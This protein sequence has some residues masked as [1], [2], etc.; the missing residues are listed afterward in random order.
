MSDENIHISDAEIAAIA[1]RIDRPIVLVGL[2]G[3][4]KSTV[5][6]RLASLVGRDFADADDEIERAAQLSV[7][8]IFARFGE[9]HFR[10]GERRVIARLIEE[11]HGVIA[12]GGG[13]FCDPGTR[14]LILEQAIAVWI[15]C[16]VDT[17]VE[18]T[19]RKNNRPLLANGNPREILT[20]LKAER[21][22]YYSQ[23]PIKVAGRDTPHLE[24]ALN[25]LEAID[26]WL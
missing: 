24:T 2:M 19:S 11:R 10:D 16:D 17:L 25:I 18:R 3:A 23:A 14:A 20:R 6:R 26:R 1:R 13:A 5:G 4:G 9:P 15:D 22:P 7:A 12:T 21:D 8:D